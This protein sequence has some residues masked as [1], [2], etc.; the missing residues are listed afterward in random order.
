MVRY[1]GAVTEVE[2]H[3]VI[4]EMPRMLI[5]E[6]LM[7]AAVIYQEEVLRQVPPVERQ[8]AAKQVT[9]PAHD[10]REWVQVATGRRPRVHSN[11]H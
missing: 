5:H 2:P 1:L 8:E 10:A 11:R 7:E 6:Q 4:Q 3:R 9:V